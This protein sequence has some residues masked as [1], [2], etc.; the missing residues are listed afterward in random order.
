M[1][2][3][4]LHRSFRRGD[5]VIDPIVIEVRMLGNSKP[6][7]SMRQQV[8]EVVGVSIIQSMVGRNDR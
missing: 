5:H 7:V 8:L 2:P 4:P 1:T 6:Y 3:E